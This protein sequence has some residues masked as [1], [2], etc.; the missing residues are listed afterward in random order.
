M[1][2]EERIP[3]GLKGRGYRVGENS[4]KEKNMK[5]KCDDECI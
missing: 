3:G 2:A 5:I 4:E 1:E